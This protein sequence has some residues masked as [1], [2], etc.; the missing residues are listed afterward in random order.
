MKEHNTRV[1]CMYAAYDENGN[2]MGA[3]W[4]HN[5]AQA[6]LIL[7]CRHPDHAHISRIR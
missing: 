5:E 7:G 4:H 2:I 1:N 3:I 6:K